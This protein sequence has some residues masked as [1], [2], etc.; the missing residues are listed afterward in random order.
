MNDLTKAILILATS[1]FWKALA[2]ISVGLWGLLV[3]QKL[4][5][6][7]LEYRLLQLQVEKL[8]KEVRS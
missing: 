3:F 7:P 4:Y 2:G 1:P 8:K 6:L 5:N